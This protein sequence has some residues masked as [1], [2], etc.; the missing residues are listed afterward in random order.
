MK[1]HEAKDPPYAEFCAAQINWVKIEGGR[2]GGDD[3]ALIPF[4]R[5]D[6]FVKG[7]SGN[8]ECPAS[9]RVESRRKRPE[10]SLN[11]PRVDGY[12]EYT[13]YVTPSF[14][15]TIVAF[16]KPESNYA[17]PNVSV[18]PDTFEVILVYWC[19]YGPEDYRDNESHIGENSSIKPASGKGSRPGRRHMMRGCICHFTVKRLYNRP[20]LALII[21]NQR[22]H[23]DKTGAPCHGILDEEAVGT[24]AMYAPRISDELRQKVMSMIHVGISLD[25][26]VQHHMEEVQRHGGP[27]N[28]DDFLTRNDVRNMERLIRNSTHELHADDQ[29]SLKMW[30]QRHHK[31]VFYFQE[32]SGSE[33]FVI[34]IQTDWQ[35]QQMLRYG[36]SGYIASHSASA[37]KKLKY[38][39]CSLL[40]F[41][42]SQNAIPV[43]WIITSSS[44][45]QNIRK[46]MS[47]LIKRIRGKDTRW[48]P[49]AFLVDDPLFEA[50]VI[51]EAFQC[52][53]LLCLWRVRHSW[54]KILLKYCNNF[55]L[56]REMFKHLGRILYC[57]RNG[58]STVDA[59]E[60][61]MQIYVDQSAFI[62]HFRCKWLPDIESWVKC[63]RTLPV[64]NQE[65]YASIESYHLRLKS[66]VLSLLPSNSHQRVDFLIHVVTTQFHSFYWFDQYIAET[67]YF[68]N[69]RDRFSITNPWYQAMHISDIDVLLD[70]ENLQLAK[71]VS[72]TDSNIAYTIWNPGSEFALC[73]CSWSM[74]GNM[75]KHTIKVAIFCRNRQIA[76]PLLS[77]QV[78]RQTLVDL[79]LNLPDDPLVL[80]HAISH[81]TRLQQDIKSLEDL[82]NNG[83]LQPLS[84]GTNSTL[85][86]NIQPF[87]RIN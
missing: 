34:G 5:V 71:V 74:V 30:A 57:T 44:H 85:A 77:A 64:A 2:Q 26:I 58:S 15:N 3:I 67:G 50:S 11:K 69:L 80:E 17:L 24:R 72:Q 20:Q 73:D 52:R 37:S 35:L 32:S 48:R 36:H 55:D 87:R 63:V 33:P 25:N 16:E 4:S 39:I 13:L 31:H 49:N 1:G 40:V 83:L 62:E 76:R 59:V 6:D 65:P 82:S 29:C 8:A 78:Y 60:E 43:V 38:T 86:D 68:E 61:F 53:V 81:V 41:D 54:L 75:C 28:R 51:R 21:Y 14:V 79:L 7:E 70:E 22:N 42:S 47:S 56:Q 19:S 12:L 23:V 45:C 9:F 10:G 66:R 27:H 46:W 18:N 84:S